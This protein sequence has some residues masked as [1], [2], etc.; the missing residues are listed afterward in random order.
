MRFL[1]GLLI[2]Y[3]R[4]YPAVAAGL[5]MVRTSAIFHDMV[6]SSASSFVV[7]NG[8]ANAFLIAAFTSAAKS[9]YRN[10]PAHGR[11]LARFAAANAARAL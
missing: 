10:G 2:R 4:N 6:A 1:H 8:I 11:L 5:S 7:I 9:R 3:C